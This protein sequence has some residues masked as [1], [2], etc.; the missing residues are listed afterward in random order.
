MILILEDNCDRTRRFLAAAEAVAPGIPVR[1]WPNADDMIV[2]L[3]ELLEN[4]MLISLDHD[5]TPPPGD[6]RDPGTGYDVAKFLAELI[7]C[8]PMIIHTSNGDRA[9]WMTGELTRAGWPITRVYPDG[10]DWIET[11]WAATVKGLLGAR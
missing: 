8:C 3:I 10:E 9:N 11:R 1:I 2:D 6:R 5:L 4:A 7:P